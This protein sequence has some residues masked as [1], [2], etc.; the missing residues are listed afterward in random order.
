LAKEQEED[1]DVGSA[2]GVEESVV[3]VADEV[4]VGSEEVVKTM[5]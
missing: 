5:E 4:G 2:A 3:G 1:A